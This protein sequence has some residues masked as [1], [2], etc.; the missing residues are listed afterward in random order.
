MLAAFTELKYAQ[1]VKRFLQ[2][3]KILQFSYNPIK[4]LNHIY[5]P[6]INTKIK[7]IPQ[8]KIVN[9][10]FTFTKRE[11][12]LDTKTLLRGKLNTNEMELLPRAQEIIGSIMIL[13]IPD[14]LKSKEKIIAEAFLN[15]NKNIKTVVKKDKIHSGTFRTRKVKILAGIKTKQTT[16][17]ENGVALKVH[18]ENA[19]YSSRTANERL[20]IAKQVKPGEKILVMF[21]GICPLSLVIAR[22]S[23]PKKIV[24]V[25]LNPLAHQL[26]LQNVDLNKM[27]DKIVVLEGNVNRIIPSLRQKFDRILLPLPK[28]GELFFPLAL[29]KSKSGTI[30]HLYAF[31]QENEINK[32]KQN[33]RRVSPSI[34]FLKTVKCGQFSPSVYRICFDIKVL[35]LS[36]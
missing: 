23:Q 20:R 18:L 17:H 10:K 1:K 16:H 35:K 27:Q 21:S 22:N 6:I 3:K 9:T 2:S 31:L 24:S 30:I 33:I 36:K 13:E 5:F 34:R 19:Y 28:T 29:K 8:A 4:E 26:A 25:E 11:R 14:K 7:K 32:F 12:T 15:S